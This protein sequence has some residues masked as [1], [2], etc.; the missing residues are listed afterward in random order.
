MQ[1]GSYIGTWT[2]INN[3]LSVTKS[4]PDESTVVTDNI[5]Y[6]TAVATE[7]CVVYDQRTA[8]YYVLL[9]AEQFT[10]VEL[11]KAIITEFELKVGSTDF[12]VDGIHY[13]F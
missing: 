11:C 12:V 2:W 1:Y 3:Q 4:R 5:V 6:P 8:C 13:V 10:N 7:N 9:S